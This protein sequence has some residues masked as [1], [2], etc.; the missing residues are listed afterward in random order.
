MKTADTAKSGF[1]HQALLFA[2]DFAG[3][4]RA[5]AI[6]AAVLAVVAAASESIGLV[7]LVPFISIATESE[8]APGWI[9]Q[10]V[11]SA[12]DFAGAHTRIARLTFLL[13]IF[14]VLLIIRALLVARR[15]TALS[16]LQ[17]GFVEDIR[18]RIAQRLAAAPW[19]VVSR[20]QHARV[21]HALGGDIQRIAGAAS[22]MV[23]TTAAV[24]LMAFQIAIALVLA[25]VLSAIA[26]ALIA[27]G[28]LAS[29]VTLRRAHHLG[30]QLSRTSIA[31]THETTQFLGGLKLAAAQNRQADFVT[32]FA[33]SL[34]LLKRQQFE[35]NRQR[36]QSQL[37]STVITGLVGALI[38]FVGFAVFDT[39]APVLIAL[40]LVFARISAPA[41]QLSQAAQQFAHSLPAYGEVHSWNAT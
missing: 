39:P 19:S 27:I 12:L 5:Q 30:E 6:A 23:Q 33:R 16:D 17:L 8:T 24:V 11:A 1:V 29:F 10:I 15:N 21:T 25:P 3:F 28:A 32:E 9:H 38:A 7:L 31:L 14:F 34:T 4:A 36:S 40:L 20:L 26:I 37:A 18:S 2:G 35:F 13:A 41:A 22:F